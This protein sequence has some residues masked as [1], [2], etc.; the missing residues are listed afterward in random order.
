MHDA[1]IL[2]AAGIPTGVVCTSEFAEAA[3]DQA[4][5]LGL[6]EYDVIRVDHPMATLPPEEVEQRARQARVDIL[7][8]L[9]RS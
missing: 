4:R 9:T 8:L 7:R 6:G 2:E 1:R 3:R 5:A